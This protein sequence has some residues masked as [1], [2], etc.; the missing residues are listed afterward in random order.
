MEYEIAS[1]KVKEALVRSMKY[2]A[3][4]SISFFIGLASVVSDVSSVA[5]HAQTV[6]F[7]NELSGY[8]FFGRGKLK[9]VAFGLSKKQDIERLFGGTCEK[10]CDYDE[11]FTINIDY[12]DC[13]DCMTTTY[14][15]DR[16]MCPLNE[17]MG[18]IEKIT[19][20]PKVP[21]QL[22]KIPTTRFPKNTGGAILFKNG[23][24]GV[25]YESFG[26][27]F[28]LKYSIKKGSTASVTITTPGPDFMNGSLYSIEYG[29]SVELE[30]KIFKAEYKT[31]MK[32]APT[33]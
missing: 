3:V 25:S 28:G 21:V 23:S 4:F 11:R 2:I 10:G 8:E 27:E 33:N 26:D 5:T 1:N 13:D 7:P 16:A 31:C 30:T 15:R 6:P 24:G 9:P 29:L 32:P 17:Y 20:T 19:L 14:V 18:T 12:L 22:E